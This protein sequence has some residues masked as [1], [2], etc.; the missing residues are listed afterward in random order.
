MLGH[1]RLGAPSP[2]MLTYVGDLLHREEEALKIHPIRERSEL[3]LEGLAKSGIAVR[4]KYAHE[5]K[6][7]PHAVVQTTNSSSPRGITPK[8]EDIIFTETDAN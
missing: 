7:P 1:K 6:T 4:D 8:S 5:A 3:Y 2:K